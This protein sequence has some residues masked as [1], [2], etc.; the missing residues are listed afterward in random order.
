MPGHTSNSKL[1]RCEEPVLTSHLK[2]LE[3]LSD[4]GV[5]SSQQTSSILAQLP[6]E[7]ESSSRQVQQPIAAD[8]VPPA[9]IQEAIPPPVVPVQQPA[10]APAPVAAPVPAPAPYLPPTNQFA[11][12]TLNEKAPVPSPQ[13]YSPPP[14]PP[15]A[16][17]GP[18]VMSMASAVYEYKA[19]ESGDLSFLPHDRIQVLE[20][21]NNDCMMAFVS[22]P[23][24]VT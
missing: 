12:T 3:F 8:P 13:Q 18:P 20:H 14:V 15:P 10:P 11:N 19:S 22:P 1:N 9:P 4:L 5:L 16:Y 2:E 23:V 24:C 21:M 17:Q 7:N 6:E